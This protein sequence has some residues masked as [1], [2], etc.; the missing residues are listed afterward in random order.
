MDSTDARATAAA[1]LYSE[2]FGFVKAPPLSDPEV[3]RNMALALVAV[4]SGDG[5]LSDAERGWIVGYF[6]AKGY[7]QAVLDEVTAIPAPKPGPV[8][9][10]MD[11]GIL[12]ASRRILVYDAN[13]PTGTTWARACRTRRGRRARPRRGRGRADRSAR[14]RRA[15]AEAEAHR[16]LDAGRAPEP[17]AEV[18]GL[19]APASSRPHARRGVA[20]ERPPATRARTSEGHGRPC[21]NRCHLTLL[22]SISS[23]VRSI[24]SLVRSISSLVRSISSLIHSISSL[25]HSISSLVRSISS[26]IRPYPSLVRRHPSKRCSRRSEGWGCPCEG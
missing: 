10:L 26:L 9:D 11:L 14:R 18:T 6:A 24:S 16:H 3:V 4:A 20:N 8:A 1:W 5:K 21:F 19:A 7:P 12:R 23:L 13:A 15:C 2:H 22:H 25:V 17:R